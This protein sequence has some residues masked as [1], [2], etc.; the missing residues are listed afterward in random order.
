M[1]KSNTVNGYDEDSDSKVGLFLGVFFV[2]LF[3]VSIGHC[4]WVG[5][6]VAMASVGLISV[7]CFL[8]Y[9]VG[10][11]Q[12]IGSST[13]ASLGL[14]L[15]EP[16]S[17]RLVPYLEKQFGQSV[18]ASAGML[19]SG[20]GIALLVITVFWIVGII[21][22]RRSRFLKRCDQYT[23]FLFGLGNSVAVV[24]LLLWGLLASEST[25]KQTQRHNGIANQ[26]NVVQGMNQVLAATKNSYVMI[27][28][29]GWNPYLE[30]P[31]FQEIKRQ[32]D[33]MLVKRSSGEVDSLPLNVGPTEPALGLQKLIQFMS[34]RQ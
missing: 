9:C 17:N 22:L 33:A 20:L 16:T 4:W 25:I 5:D 23:G 29:N 30:V 31:Q 3:G 18:P 2:F 7:G 10:L 26:D 34:N 32:F 6:L 28:L 19:V 27:A 13:G 8:G 24:A 1:Q 21:V 14:L 15:A 12:T 11:W